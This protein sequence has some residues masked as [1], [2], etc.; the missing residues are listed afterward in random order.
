MLAYLVFMDTEILWHLLEIYGTIW[1]FWLAKTVSMN[2]VV[3][4]GYLG[5]EVSG[6]EVSGSV[7][8]RSGREPS[9]GEMSGSGFFLVGDCP[10]G[11]CPGENCPW[12]KLSDRTCPGGNCPGGNLPVI[13][14]TYTQYPY[15]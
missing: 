5:G 11:N 6:R 1:K 3:V 4:L 12:G 14:Y 7:F 9:S 15:P 2:R 10:G 13:E 8:R